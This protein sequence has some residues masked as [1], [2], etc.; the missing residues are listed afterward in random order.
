[1]V[2][3]QAM[4]VHYVA[5]AAEG[6]FRGLKDFNAVKMF[7]KKQAQRGFLAEKEQRCLQE[8]E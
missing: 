8:G 4:G 3:K 5:I 6:V 2:F 1:M 7:S